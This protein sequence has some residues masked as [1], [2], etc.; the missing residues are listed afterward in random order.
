MNTFLR[1]KYSMLCVLITIVNQLQA[2]QHVYTLHELVNASQ[3][4]IPLLKQQQSIIKSAEAAVV[5]IKHS[6]LPQLKI[7]DQLSIGTD[8]S[9]AGTY[10]PLMQV[11]SASGGIR[12]TNNY[13]PATG[14]I[15]IYMANM[16]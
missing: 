7:S 11:P 10:L 9:T 15:G 6:F 5:D 2:Q 14:N 8:N 1:R 4:F 16:N 12:A 3:Q 13:Q